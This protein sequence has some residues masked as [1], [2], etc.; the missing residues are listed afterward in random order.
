MA[1]ICDAR[2][3]GICQA[4]PL[5]LYKAISLAARSLKIC[6]YCVSIATSHFK[7]SLRN[8]IDNTV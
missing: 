3:P 2:I 7:F 1:Q 5:R 8:T 4:K 6:L